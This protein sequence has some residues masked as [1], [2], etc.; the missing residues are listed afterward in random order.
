MN[1]SL[2]AKFNIVLVLI[3]LAGFAVAAYVSNA[4]LLKNAREEVLQDARILMESALASRA[5]TIKH[6]KPLLENQM[7]YQMVPESVPS[8]AA[9][10]NL[11]TVR[12]NFPEYTYKEATLNPTN[13]RDRATGWEV[14][15]V[16]TLR[17]NNDMPEFV[18]DRDDV[19]GAT[20]YIA[21][22]IKIKDAACLV[23]HS[24]VDVAPKTL[25]D[26]YGPNNGFGWGFQET[27][28]AQIVTVP[29]SVAL[30]RAHSALV[31]FLGSLLGIFLAIFIAF[32][33]MLRVIITRPVLRLAKF[34]DSVSMGHLEEPDITVK[35]SDEIAKLTE[36]FNR[37]RNSTVSALKMLEGE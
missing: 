32:N 8:F 22:P 6:I 5:Y 7:K 3:F 20:L 36:A 15:V 19:S 21:R 23:C 11:A 17:N 27:V 37:M 26:A 18:G 10:E 33:V 12:K 24:T 13:P 30:Q 25:I 34:A 29:Q 14:D 2:T 9:T 35:G 16:Q 31:T 28:G 1:L 4:L